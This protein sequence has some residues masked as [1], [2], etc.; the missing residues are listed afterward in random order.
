MRLCQQLRLCWLCCALA[1]AVQP[2]PTWIHLSG[3]TLMRANTNRPAGSRRPPGCA[4][5]AAAAA[6]LQRNRRQVPCCPQRHL[7]CR[8]RRTVLATL[9]Q[10]AQVGLLRSGI[11]GVKGWLAAKQSAATATQVQAEARRTLGPPPGTAT[12]L[13][14]RASIGGSITKAAASLGVR[15]AAAAAATS[16]ACCSRSNKSCSGSG[17]EGGSSS[18]PP[19]CGNTAASWCAGG[20]VAPLASAV[21]TAAAGA[22]PVPAADKPCRLAAAGPSLP[23]AC[24][25]ASSISTVGA[26]DGSPS[27]RCPRQNGRLCFCCACSCQ[28]C[29]SGCATR[30][31]S[32]CLRRRLASGT[33]AAAPTPAEAA[34][35][36]RCS[37][38]SS[39]WPGA[40]PSLLLAGGCSLLRAR[41]FGS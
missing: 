9:Q 3:A 35:C 32:P 22:S 26:S 34:G 28:T 27:D 5:V 23:A 17:A 6:A 38:C 4:S 8:R 20:A 18:C 19:G 25:A 13:T 40:L 16:T 7:H 29:S 11:K 36:W 33:G 12:A 2:A 14:R 30:R 37:G 31:G 10:A 21:A 41:F 1:P 24:A 15:P 39:C